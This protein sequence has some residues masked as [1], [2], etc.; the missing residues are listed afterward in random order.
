M[1]MTDPEPSPFLHQQ[2]GI[3]VDLGIVFL[4]TPRTWALSPASPCHRSCRTLQ[5]ETLRG[6]PTTPS[7]AATCPRAAASSPSSASTRSL[8]L[9]ASGSPDDPSSRSGASPTRRPGAGVDQL[10]QEPVP[11]EPPQPLHVQTV[12]DVGPARGSLTC[13]LFTRAPSMAQPPHPSNPVGV[14]L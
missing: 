5:P 1:G 14:V 9:A 11:P 3:P 2:P 6:C 4:I 10:P 7:P 13:P 12:I 8:T